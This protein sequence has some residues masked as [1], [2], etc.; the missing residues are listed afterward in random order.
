HSADDDVELEFELE[1]GGFIEVYFNEDMGL[2]QKVKLPEF[3][4][5]S[6]NVSQNR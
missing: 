3:T 4:V 1:K 2:K 5:T 6:S